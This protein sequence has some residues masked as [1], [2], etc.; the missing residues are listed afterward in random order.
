M[1]EIADR[2]DPRVGI[3]EVCVSTVESAE[4]AFE[5]GAD[6]LELCSH[7]DRDGLTPT[8]ELFD[9]VRSRVPLP[10]I[11]MIRPHDRGYRYSDEEF[12]DMLADAERFLAEGARGIAVGVLTEHGEVDRPRLTSLR[13]AA[14]E[15][16][17]VFHRAFDEV[18]APADALEVL[19]ECGATRML[20]SGGRETAPQGSEVLRSLS[21]LAGGRVE[22]LPGGG[23]RPENVE[24]L[25]EKSGCTQVHG[26]FRSGSG[27]DTET[28][29][30]AVA[31]VRRA[32]D[33]QFSGQAG[34]P[35]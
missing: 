26:T 9:A 12:A 3:L 34:G 2:T 24:R 17:L 22:V 28:N 8:F 21:E 4:A 25:L 18:G 10:I 30:A 32:L 14:G 35:C 7:L 5:G 27:A 20:T 15:A 6:R 23:I 33:R 29:A 16:E 11:V 19:V 1:S 31:S 13:T